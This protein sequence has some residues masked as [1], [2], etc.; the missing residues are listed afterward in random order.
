MMRRLL[1]I[2]TVLLLT[3]ALALADAR[4][5]FDEGLRLYRNND[6]DGA[7]AAWEHV[8]QQGDVSGPL[9]Y[10]L[11]N[12]YYRA[13]K[14]G[15]AILYYERARKLLP[16]DHDITSNLDLARMATVD[17]IEPT[18]RLVV[19]NWVDSVRDH[20]NVHELASMFYVLGLFCAMA[21]LMFRYGPSGLR[22][23]FKTLTALLLVAYILSGSWYLW[24]AT[25]EG[26]RYGV[27][28]E[29]KTDAYSAPDDASKQL[30]SLHEGTKVQFGESLSGWVNVRL[31]DGRKGWIPVQSLE[32]I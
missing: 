20:Y 32:K 7:I 25:L 23:I 1:I 24:R 16:R 8:V 22:R 6:M 9:Y 18:V 4:S 15:M 13:K 19:W 26:R 28:M 30:F 17:K 3:C 2:F 11:G 12:A 5:G 31:A 29:T 27:V 14:Y 21:L 10:N